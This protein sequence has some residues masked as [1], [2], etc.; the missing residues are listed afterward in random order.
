MSRSGKSDNQKVA[1]KMTSLVNDVTID[2]T[3][4]GEHIART[5]PNVTYRRFIEIADAAKFER[6]EKQ[7]GTDHIF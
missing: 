7:N 6:E 1:E 4:V 2:L 3:T 5:A